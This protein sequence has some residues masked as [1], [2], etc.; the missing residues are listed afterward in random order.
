MLENRLIRLTSCICPGYTVVYECTIVG[1]SAT[2]WNG[3][4]FNCS[5]S[6][7]EIIL[8]HPFESGVD[9]TMMCNDGNIFGRGI[10]TDTRNI[11][12]SRLYVKVSNNLIGKS[13]VCTSDS[14]TQRMRET[15]SITEGIKN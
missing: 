10:K 1:G 15:I 4:A 9:H 3:N 12:I 5:N 13:I 7:D 8:L 2:V 11:H 14:D 6:H